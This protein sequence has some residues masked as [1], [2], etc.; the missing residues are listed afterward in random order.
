MPSDSR[1]Q[2]RRLA[3]VGGNSAVSAV[4]AMVSGAALS[5]F[6][7]GR[8]GGPKSIAVLLAVMFGIGLASRAFSGAMIGVLEHRRSR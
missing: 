6:L 5:V 2:A 3:V 4:I 8:G 7:F 1:S